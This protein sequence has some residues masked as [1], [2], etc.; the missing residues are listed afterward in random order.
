MTFLIC[1]QRFYFRRKR[2]ASEM[3]KSFIEFP[4]NHVTSNESDELPSYDQRNQ[5]VEHSESESESFLNQYTDIQFEDVES[6]IS[7][8]DYLNIDHS[9]VES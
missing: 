3:T 4:N 7:S 8:L 9:N 5:Y 1:N 6:L 2:P